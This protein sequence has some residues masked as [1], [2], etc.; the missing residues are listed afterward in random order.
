MAS[1]ADRG[2]YTG[3]LGSVMLK[4]QPAVLG[5]G[6]VLYEFNIIFVLMAKGGGTKVP[7]PQKKCKF[8][9]GHRDFCAVQIVSIQ[10]GESVKFY[11]FLKNNCL[12]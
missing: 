11:T 12:F 1:W 10:H 2:R 5:K 4:G 3:W 8:L 7:M 6:C 9:L